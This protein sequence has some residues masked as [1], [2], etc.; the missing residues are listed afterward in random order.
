[1]AF[2]RL[3]PNNIK[4]EIVGTCLLTGVKMTHWI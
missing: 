3:K 4:S 1:M 2:Y